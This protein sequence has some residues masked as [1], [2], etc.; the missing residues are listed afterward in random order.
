MA[1]TAR[2]RLAEVEGLLQASRAQATELCQQL[3]DAHERSARY[4]ALQ[5]EL[6]E[7]RRLAE[8]LQQREAEAQRQLETRRRERD[9]AEQALRAAESDGRRRLEAAQ[10]E[11]RQW[12]SECM[13]IASLSAC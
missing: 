3:T 2:S 7:Q 12:R 5:A 10:A 11:V 6:D 8:G 4:D 13:L 1:E 9:E